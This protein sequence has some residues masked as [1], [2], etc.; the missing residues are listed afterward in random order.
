[1]LYL[2]A[3]FEDGL[4][5][6]GGNRS[7]CGGRSP[8]MD[9]GVSGGKKRGHAGVEG[10]RKRKGLAE[11]RK[12]K[13]STN[14]LSFFFSAPRRRRA[15]PLVAKRWVGGSAGATIRSI[16]RGKDQT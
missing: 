8:P 10:R 4:F 3:A 9:S 13:S 11:G 1:M 5:W 7:A 6:F 15:S 16:L 12:E 14:E 2:G